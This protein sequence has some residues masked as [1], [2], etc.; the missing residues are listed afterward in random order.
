MFPTGRTVLR[1]LVVARWLTWVWMVAVVTVSWRS[2]IR[3]PVLAVL[4]IVAVGAMAAWCTYAIRSR[5]AAL[6]TAGFVVAEAS[7]ALGLSVLDGLVF[8]PGHVF[9]T[10]Q[11]L[12]TQ[13]PLIAMVSIGF[14]A[15]PWVAAGI[16]LLMGPAEWLGAVL[17]EFDDWA[18]RHA[19]SLAATSLF[20]AI[21][22]W[23]LGWLADLLR[24]TEA[25]IADRRARDE[26]AN[27][28]HDTVLQTLA[29]V[30]R[31]TAESD[32][33]L[34]RAARDADRDL[35][36]FLF[37]AP[38]RG[39]ESLDQLV[40]E[41]VDRATRHHDGDVLVNVLVGDA[42]AGPE[43]ERSLAGAVGEAVTNAVK[44]A[45]ATRIVVFV[46]TDDDGAIF[47][48]VRDD[49][50][51][52]DLGGTPEGNGLERSIRGRMEE[53]GGRAEVWSSPGIGTEVRLWTT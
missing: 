22:G 7:L 4:S 2:A 36:R 41:S 28:L 16:G 37:G 48:S 47:A 20:F 35:R 17:N 25:E 39:S 50:V 43:A 9:E 26:V 42:T 21:A 52:F 34:A 51:G 8:E 40:R 1:A 15:G 19:V 45:D 29:L 49:G 12:A 10:S 53:V 30:E 11:S 23:M 31:R 5:P 3:A 27:V 33:E 32:P 13:Y 24:R 6:S 44:H 38:S 46:E 14:V 18:P